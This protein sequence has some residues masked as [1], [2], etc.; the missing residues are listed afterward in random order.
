MTKVHKV[1]HR[2]MFLLNTT[3]T[4]RMSEKIIL[5]DSILFFSP[6]HCTCFLSKDKESSQAYY[7]PISGKEELVYLF[8]KKLAWCETQTSSF[9]SWNLLVDS[10]SYDHNYLREASSQATVVRVEFWLCFLIEYVHTI[11]YF[12]YLEKYRYQK[13]SLTSFLFH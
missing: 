5:A 10:I 3:G 12:L 6:P 13:K 1:Y 9:R 4:C 8:L 7:L 11:D 2:V